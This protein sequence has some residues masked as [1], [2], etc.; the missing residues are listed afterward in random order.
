M[1][2]QALA[3]KTASAAASSALL[4]GAFN[5]VICA[6]LIACIDTTYV[7]GSS[8][9]WWVC[10]AGCSLCAANLLT[11]LW[12][13][14]YP[15]LLLP[16][17]AVSGTQQQRLL[18]LSDDECSS[19]VTKSPAQ[20]TP[21]KNISFSDVLR[22][23][24]RTDARADLSVTL[25]NSS[26]LSWASFG[27]SSPNASFNQSWG[28][29]SPLGVTGCVN[30]SWMS[31]C[32]GN[33]SSGGAGGVH[34][35]CGGGAV[36]CAGCVHGTA[37]CGSCA[38]PNPN[39]SSQFYLS[40]PHHQCNTSFNSTGVCSNNGSLLSSP[41][42]SLAA[43]SWTFLP[44]FP[45]P[46]STLSSPASIPVPKGAPITSRQELNA[47]IAEYQQKCANVSSVLERCS[48]AAGGGGGGGVSGGL[49]C[50]TN[51]GGSQQHNLTDSTITL[52]RNTYQKATPDPV[53]RSSSG[54][55]SS[56]QSK[57]PSSSSGAS[58]ATK[59]WARRNVSPRLLFQFE[60]NLRIWLCA[61][62]VQPLVRAIDQAN[63]ALAD[64]APDMQ[65]GVAGVEKLR[66]AC[67]V[68]SVGTRQLSGLVPF[69]ELAPAQQH[70]LV[71]RLRQLAKGGALSSY[72]WDKGG[73]GWTEQCPSDA[74]LLVQL[75][76]LYLDSQLPPDPSQ[77]EGRVFSSQHLVVA[78][79]K[80][81][82]HP[83]HPIIHVSQLSPPHVCVLLP[84]EEPCEVGEGHKNALH[85]LLLFIHHL[86]HTQHSL[87]A[88]INLAL[89][90]VNIAWVVTDSS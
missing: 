57:D 39:S 35:S 53:V 4:W 62:A 27:S 40:P 3:R 79:E 78:P 66:K 43:T 50:Y 44:Q 28:S 22:Q 6:V 77:L 86:V 31:G 71:G 16:P 75:F 10:F 24:R 37:A 11:H 68:S 17:V 60:E 70:Y 20:A 29:T 56:D 82:Q 51:S 59:V 67:S 19:Q 2:W 84:G 65:I 52:R 33:V 49:W 81:P 72:C 25:H 32:G 90:G 34:A 14:L 47:Y 73:V 74:L 1:V 23:T 42:T 38:V 8:L 61:A 88:G 83:E 21:V 41:N 89:T 64:I 85:C 15:L 48:S 69:L 26:A 12:A 87:L 18:S 9:F 54:T 7:S 5:F 55:G 30:T 46:P 36:V 13:Y 63:E 76:A 58:Q 80:P 45:S